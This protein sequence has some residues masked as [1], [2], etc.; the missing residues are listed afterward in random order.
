MKKGRLDYDYEQ[1]DRLPMFG[2]SPLDETELYELA[3]ELWMRMRWL[4][5][6]IL[7]W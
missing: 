1:F 6:T 2:M 4:T 5:T 7:P 3:C